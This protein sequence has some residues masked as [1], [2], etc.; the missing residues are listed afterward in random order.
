LSK[1][2]ED[3]MLYLNGKAQ[4]SEKKIQYHNDNRNN[5]YASLLA[6]KNEVKMKSSTFEVNGM[7]AIIKPLS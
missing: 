5:S 7:T 1:D 3:D 2:L 6:K 4:E